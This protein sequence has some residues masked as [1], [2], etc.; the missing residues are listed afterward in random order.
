MRKLSD[1]LILEHHPN[2]SIGELPTLPTRLKIPLRGL[3]LIKS[4]GSPIEQLM[5][6]LKDR[7]KLLSRVWST[8]F[9]QT[10]FQS[11]EY[12]VCGKIAKVIVNRLEDVSTSRPQIEVQVQVEKQ[13]NAFDD[14]WIG[15][16][17]SDSATQQIKIEK[18][19][20]EF[21]ECE[22]ETSNVN[23]ES[24]TNNGST[25]N[26]MARVKQENDSSQE[27]APECSTA[28]SP[29]DDDFSQQHYLIPGYNLI[30]IKEEEY[31]EKEAEGCL[32]ESEPEMWP[33]NCSTSETAN[34]TEVGG[35]NAHSISLV[36]ECT[37]P[38]VAGKKIKL[39]S[40][41]DCSYKTPSITHWKRHMTKHTGE[42][43]FSFEQE[44]E[45]SSMEDEPEMWSSNCSTSE[46]ANTKEVGGLNQH[47]ISPV[48]TYI[49]PT[50]AGKKTK[51]YSCADCSYKTTWIRNIKR[52]NMRKHTGEKPFSCELCDFKC[53]DSYA[54]KQHIRTHTG[55]T[56]FSC[57]YC[58][59]RCAR[60][61]DLKKHIRTHTGETP[62]SC[63]YCDYKCALSCNL[64]RHIRKHTG[65][66]P[67]SCEYCD[68]KCGQS[69]TLKKHIRTHT[70]ETP[71]SCEY[72]DYKCAQSGTLKAHIRTHTGETPFSCEY[73]DYKCA[74][75]FTLKRHIRTH[76]RETPFSCEFCEY[77]CSLSSTLKRH[78]R[79]HTRETPFSCE[80]CDYKCALS[81]TLKIHIRTHTRETPYSCEFC[82]YKCAQSSTLKRHIRT[83][84][85]E[86]T[87]S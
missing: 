76:T 59:Y 82:E 26:Q 68:Y 1:R 54:L 21:G 12:H 13:E 73:C 79:T 6:R 61:S 85:G 20:D 42:K 34:A 65:E 24:S 70:G 67:L 25:S 7:V 14:S 84:I 57:E 46:T 81:S 87:S 5:F 83:H 44:A 55:E 56:P 15:A 80:F 53:S 52:H 58:D 11:M 37:E 22:F 32:V 39:Y 31:V 77:K 16:T 23:D 8:M 36:E 50:V 18:Q 74:L 51:L 75:S 47:S 69:G 35:L 60:T 64:K 45:G 41:A 33:S 10:A 72:C 30:F 19:E 3:D 86:T 49:E 48:E 27:P 28:C 2:Q 62:F 78:I 71:F 66:T 17:C 38:S 4:I 43:P 63:E 40:C 9:S 29:T